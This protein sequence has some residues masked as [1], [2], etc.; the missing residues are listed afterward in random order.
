MP[1][2]KKNQPISIAIPTL[3]GAPVYT[4]VRNEEDF[5]NPYMIRTLHVSQVTLTLDGVTVLAK[6]VSCE[7]KDFGKTVFTTKKAVMQEIEKLLDSIRKKKGYRL[8]AEQNKGLEAPEEY[9]DDA[10][11]EDSENAE[12]L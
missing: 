10:E 12:V 2:G 5:A 6:N 1:K 8:A 9:P 4:I 7:E 11:E 3:P